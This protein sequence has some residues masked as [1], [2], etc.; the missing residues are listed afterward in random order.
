MTKDENR[1]KQESISG[2][3]TVKQALDMA[4]QQHMAGRLAEAENLYLKILESE[5]DQPV[6]LHF[7]GVI[8]HQSDN[9]DVAEDFIARAISFSP[10]YTEAHN[11]LGIVLQKLGRL[12]DA[13]LSCRKAITLNPDFA[14]AYNN[15]GNVLQE[16]GRLEDAISSYEKALSL[17]PDPEVHTNLGSAYQ[18][19]GRLDDAVA[20]YQNAL[21]LHPEFIEAHNYLGN[22]F[23]E[24]G[25]LKNAVISYNNAIALKPGFPEAHYNLGSA[26]QRLGEYESAVHNYQ[27]ADTGDAR[28]K[29]LE[30]LYDLERYEELH[31]ILESHAEA[32]KDNLLVA[33]ISVFIS[34][35]LDHENPHPFC[36]N[37]LDF[38]RVGKIAGSARKI[39]GL[40]SGVLGDLEDVYD[41][42]EPPSVST[43]EGYQT[44]G[45]LFANPEGN[46]AKLNTI[47]K[48]EIAAYHS[49]FKSKGGLF[50]EQWPPEHRLRGWMVRLFKGG[51]QEEHIHPGGWISGVIYLKLPKPSDGDEGCIE[52]NLGGYALPHLREE[53]PTKVHRPEKG[54]IVLFPSSLFHR[55]IPTTTDEERITLSF[56]LFPA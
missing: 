37:P 54:Q 15:L 35:Q 32:D 31:E 40:I 38:V 9:N 16:M 51:H 5:P 50:V 49:E 18:E 44:P 47:I 24:L 52:F 30:C 29:L 45:N 17:D 10:N 1:E 26:L 56:D 28:A 53:W 36:K 43:I 7:L 41:V 13:V 11:N 39:D 21:V 3:R 25:Q 34:H 8:A 33:A 46:I 42:W 12:E 2:E 14:E 55:T 27:V 23:Q 48:R 6:A 20:S 22:A 4:L 19:L